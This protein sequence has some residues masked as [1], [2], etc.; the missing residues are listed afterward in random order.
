MSNEEEQQNNNN[1]PDAQSQHPSLL[2]LSPQPSQNGLD[3]LALASIMMPL[4]R[5]IR[6]TV[7][8]YLY[9]SGIS[10][11]PFY[12]G[13]TLNNQLHYNRQN[14]I[15]EAALILA[16]SLYD[17]QPVKK[18]IDEKAKCEIIDETFKPSLVEEMKINTACGIWQEDFEEGDDIKI[19]PCKHAFKPEA[20]MKW[21]TEEKAE[22]PICRYSLESKEIICHEHIHN[23]DDNSDS[24]DTHD[25][26]D[27][28]YND[29]NNDE[30]A[31]P[32]HDD[33]HENEQNNDAIRINNIASRIVQNVYGRMNHL[34]RQLPYDYEQTISSPI[35]RLIQSRRNL[36]SNAQNYANSHYIR[37]SFP[38][39]GRGSSASAPSQSLPQYEGSPLVQE[40]NNNNYNNNNN[41]NYNNNNN[42]NNNEPV[43]PVINN[44]NNNGSIN[45]YNIIN[46][47]YYY[48]DYINNED[49]ILNQEQADIDEAIRRSLEEN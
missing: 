14:E 48:N 46:N 22:C 44:Q 49:E 21:L 45:N 8:D 31:Q 32:Q 34:N 1:I 11:L 17:P 38:L 3:A 10:V 18:V 33:N 29:N 15:D 6:P 42:N 24:D 25:D 13:I 41:N 7:L 36:I 23:N 2:S 19:L 16:R 20:I 37:N 26:D 4:S 30:E 12:G 9:N 5:S 40:I 35:N 27:D 43:V 39:F 28:E 47:I